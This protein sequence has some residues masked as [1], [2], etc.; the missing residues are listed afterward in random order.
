MW[1]DLLTHEQLL[2]CAGV[3]GFV[4]YII[5]FASL[6]LGYLDGNGIPYTLWSLAGAMLVLT[7]LMGA[8]NLA[9]MLIQVSWIIICVVG[10]IRRS[11]NSQVRHAKTR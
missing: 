3:A 4:C 8:F 1:A 5:G 11:L 10:L 9:S 6:Q 2:Q 7:S